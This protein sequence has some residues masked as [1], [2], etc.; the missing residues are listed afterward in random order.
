MP[1]PL[2]VIACGAIARELVRI[3]RA[4]GWEHIDFQCLPPALHNRPQQITAAVEHAIEAARGRYDRPRYDKRQGRNRRT[5]HKVFILRCMDHTPIRH[6]E[7]RV[8]PLTVDASLIRS[9]LHG[10]ETH[11]VSQDPAG[12]PA[13]SV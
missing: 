9:V 6:P 1:T 3:T 12:A 8:I 7:A 11:D 5:R 13:R 2:L 10:P 4:N